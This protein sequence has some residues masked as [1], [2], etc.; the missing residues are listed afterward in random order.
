MTF[1]GPGYAFQT[2]P[3]LAIDFFFEKIDKK[4]F[5]CLSL[6]LD[7]FESAENDLK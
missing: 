3:S 2:K 4:N 6:G 1:P 5:N 7:T